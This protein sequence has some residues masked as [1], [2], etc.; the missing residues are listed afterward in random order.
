MCACMCACVC[1]CVYAG[2]AQLWRMESGQKHLWAAPLIFVVWVNVFQI[3]QPVCVHAQLFGRLR[4]CL[5]SQVIVLDF[6]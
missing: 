2:Y 6:I 4:G 3:I 1:V 5:C